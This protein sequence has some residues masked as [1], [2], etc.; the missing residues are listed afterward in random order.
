MDRVDSGKPLAFSTLNGVVD[1][2]FPPDLKAD[3]TVKSTHG[4]VYSDFDVTLG[5]FARPY[6]T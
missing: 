4:P 6:R 3:L 5:G 2:T 1:V